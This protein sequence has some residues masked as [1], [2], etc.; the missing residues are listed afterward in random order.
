[1]PTENHPPLEDPFLDEVRALKERASARFDHDLT[2]IF[3]HLR[4]IERRHADRVV[5]DQDAGRGQVA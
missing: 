3:E 4:E 5:P 2:R 1:M